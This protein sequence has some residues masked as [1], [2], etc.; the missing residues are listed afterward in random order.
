MAVPKFL[1]VIF[2]VIAG[3]AVLAVV[4]VAVLLG[5]LWL[6]HTR[7]TT[8]PAP[9][10]TFAVG[11]TTY[12]WSD[13][14]QAEPVAAQP[15]THRQLVAWIWYPAAPKQPGQTYDDYLPAPW[16]TALARHGGVL[17]TQFIGF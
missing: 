4:G 6:D 2:K 13:A 11:R 5:S 7:A 10:G 17:I 3:G 12:V 16:R 1:R 15:G 14:A 9:T 8:L